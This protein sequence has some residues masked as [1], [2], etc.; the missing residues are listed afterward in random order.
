[1]MLPQKFFQV[2]I[3]PNA[4]TCK[5][6]VSGFHPMVLFLTCFLGLIAKNGA[7]AGSLT[8][9]VSE[10]MIHQEIDGVMEARRVLIQVTDPLEAEK[11]YPV[12]FALHGSGGSAQTFTGQLGHWVNAGEFVGV[13]PQGHRNTWNLGPELS[14]A[15]DLL[16]INLIMAQLAG[17]GQLD[18][19]RVFAIGFSNGAGMA[20]HI[21][22]HTDHFL[23]IAAVVTPLLVGHEP[24]ED[25]P[26]VSILQILGML[27]PLIPYDGGSGVLGHV[28]HGGE[29]SAGIWALHNG[30][31]PQPD[32]ILTDDGN[33]RLEYS[34]W[35]GQV[36]VVHYGVT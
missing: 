25:T 19:G 2:E 5:F 27:D 3:V 16:F 23:A 15:D 6:P 26:A 11:Y 12:V 8:P 7:A 35:S 22:V 21:A 24:Q 20:H 36:R 17:Y 1:M 28:F 34:G 13:Y 30:C 14:T 29:E 32:S 31:H 18:M 33:I 9:G 4:L 10:V